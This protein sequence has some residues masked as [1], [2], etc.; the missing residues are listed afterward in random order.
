VA[1]ARHRLGRRARARVRGRGAGDALLACRPRGVAGRVRP[2]R[3]GTTGVRPP[4]RRRLRGAPPRQPLAL[5]DGAA[6]GDGRG[7]GPAHRG[8]RDLRR[9]RTVRRTQHRPAD[10]GVPRARGDVARDPRARRGAPGEGARTSRGRARVGDAQRR[11]HE[12]GPDRR[13]RRCGGSATSG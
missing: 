11:A 2:Q 5:C 3:R 4:R 1:G 8:G 10:R 6:D 9:A 12:P 7:A 13:T